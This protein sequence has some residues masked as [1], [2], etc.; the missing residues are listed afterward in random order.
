MHCPALFREFSD[1]LANLFSIYSKS[2][3][4]SRDMFKIVENIKMVFD[5]PAGGK[6]PVR[7]N[8]T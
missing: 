3:N 7:C 8:G 6:I 5:L 4:K 2:P 1:M